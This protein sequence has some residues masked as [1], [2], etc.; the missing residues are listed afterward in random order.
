MSG[1]FSAP[2][3][4]ESYNIYAFLTLNKKACSGRGFGLRQDPDST[5]EEVVG[6]KVINFYGT[7]R[8]TAE[9]LI[10]GGKDTEETKNRQNEP[11]AA[12]T[13]DQSHL[14]QP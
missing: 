9:V 6:K 14:I 11:N 4:I 2:V 10:S 8:G 3:W 13:M 5:C 1:H 7:S 12:Q